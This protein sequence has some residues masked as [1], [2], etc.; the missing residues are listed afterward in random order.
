MAFLVGQ[1]IAAVGRALISQRMVTNLMKPFTT[2]ERTPDGH[3]LLPMQVEGASRT[4]F[5]ALLTGACIR[6]IALPTGQ[7]VEEAW[8]LQIGLD[9]NLVL[10]FT[11]SSTNVDGRNEVGTINL[12]V[13]QLTERAIFDCQTAVLPAPV[14]IEGVTVIQLLDGDR[15]VESGVALQLGMLGDLVISAGQLP[16]ALVVRGNLLES[17][18]AEAIKPIP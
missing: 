18:G 17:K 8:F 16:G 6:W 5:S 9:T 13:R 15:V 1:L 14:K 2:I 7:T 10:E 3:W 4:T 11:A 12:A